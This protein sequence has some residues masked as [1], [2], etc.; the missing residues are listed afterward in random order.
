MVRSE[1][2]VGAPGA[3]GDL[4][5]YKFDLEK[6]RP[7]VPVVRDPVCI[8]SEG[9]REAYAD[10]PPVVWWVAK[11]L[12]VTGT[13]GTVVQMRAQLRFKMQRDVGEDLI[14][15]Y[16]AENAD[17]LEAEREAFLEQLHRAGL[18]EELRMG[19]NPALERYHRVAANIGV[20]LDA[21]VG[22]VIDQGRTVS[23]ATVRSMVG[24][25]KDLQDADPMVAQ[26]AMGNRLSPSP[27]SGGRGGGKQ[28][29]LGDDQ[30]KEMVG[31]LAELIT[32]GG[33]ADELLQKYERRTQI[34]EKEEGGKDDG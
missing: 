24:S 26:T 9:L 33:T 11:R 6:Y 34:P 29:E 1:K 30:V 15:L 7:G 19:A 27:S 16:F 4:H 3:G 8:A 28:V 2:K 10:V 12:Y 21:M 13:A 32:K 31:K 20:I 14:A 25:L 22:D 18:E 5:K 23:P 17:D